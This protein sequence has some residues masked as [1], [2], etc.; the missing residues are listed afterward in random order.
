MSM[1][2]YQAFEHTANIY[3]DNPC[4]VDELVCYSYQEVL[5]KVNNIA[6]ELLAQNA[7]PGAAGVIYLPKQVD[8]ILWQL[9]LNKVGVAFTTLEWEQSARF[10]SVMQSLK[11]QWLITQEKG[12]V[13]VKK[14]DNILLHHCEYIIFSSGSTGV[15][16]KILLNTPAVVEVVKEQA[17]YTQMTPQSVGLWLLN[18]AFDASLSDIY[19]P[20]L[21]G[22][23]LVI[24]AIKPSNMD[25]INKLVNKWKVTHTDL[26]PVVFNLLN[27]YLIRYPDAFTTLQHIIF[28]GE[29][30]DESL[31]KHLAIR[32]HLYNAYGP[33]EATICTS[34]SKVDKA[35]T[36]DN[37][38]YPFNNVKYKI[39]DG[40][41]HIGGTHLALGYG[42]EE[43]DKKF[44]QENQTRW[45]ASGDLVE[46]KN[47]YY[48]Y[49]GRKDR[50]FKHNGQLICPEEIEAIAQKHGAQTARI[51]YKE[52]KIILRYTG[53][54]NPVDMLM[55][56]PS[57][58]MPHQYEL[59]EATLNTN[60]K[61]V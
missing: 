38:G 56:L 5:E 50:Q 46:Y 33:T 15:P 36:H 18:P 44:Y 55:D 1:K 58:M 23:M 19:M 6:K 31:V 8:I 60:W 2:L 12:T 40:E 4:L 10:E 32:F 42:H 3:P 57:W 37:I 9:A 43:L 59:R 39:I 48:C 24:S 41:L 49:K 21:S 54:L 16:K 14:L 26:P 35:W 13:L 17:M 20:L 30:A 61:V 25:E 22:A 29:R 34:M 47:N 45:Y 53:Q 7:Q 11:P 27:R 52:G 51:D 28:G